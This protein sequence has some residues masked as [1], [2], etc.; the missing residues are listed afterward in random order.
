M[1][2]RW[3]LRAVRYVFYS[4]FRG[5]VGCA[6]AIFGFYLFVELCWGFLRV[7]GFPAFRGSLVSV[8]GWYV[9]VE[10]DV[11]FSYVGSWV[12]AGLVFRRD[13]GFYV[14]GSLL[15]FGWGD[16]CLFSS[17]FVEYVL[18]DFVFCLLWLG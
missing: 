3:F 16:Y 17:F 18:F 5:G 11:S 7:R 10:F 12:C 8:V 6:V 4:V 15:V 13:L 9:S 14:K 2:W 1:V